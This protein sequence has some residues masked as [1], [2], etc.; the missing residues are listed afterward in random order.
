VRGRPWGFIDGAFP[1][2]GA[3][4]VAVI[5]SATRSPA[6]S[7][8]WWPAATCAIDDFRPEDQNPDGRGKQRHQKPSSV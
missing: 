4:T 5:K 8:L 6:R 1:S 2:A 7:L 3:A